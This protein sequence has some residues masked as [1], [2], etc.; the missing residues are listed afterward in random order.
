MV[1]L[2]CT[3]LFVTNHV[4][5]GVVPLHG[6]SVKRPLSACGSHLVQ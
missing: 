2:I 5:C 3:V 6:S 1:L 4:K